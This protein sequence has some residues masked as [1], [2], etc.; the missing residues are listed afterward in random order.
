MA[1][2]DLLAMAGVAGGLRAFS[3]ALHSLGL[4]FGTREVSKLGQA[5]PSSPI[6]DHKD[7][8]LPDES[9]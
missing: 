5:V 1:C 7:Q 3:A 4:G 8:K 9:S 2:R 6:M